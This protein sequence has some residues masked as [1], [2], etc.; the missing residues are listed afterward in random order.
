[1]F[2]VTQ[3]SS[4][5]K[6]IGE[7]IHPVSRVHFMTDCCRHVLRADTQQYQCVW[8]CLPAQVVRKCC[9][10]KSLTWAGIFNRLVTELSIFSMRGRGLSNGCSHAASKE[11]AASDSVTRRTRTFS[12]RGGKVLF[13]ISHLSYSASVD[14]AGAPYTSA[15]YFS[16]LNYCRTPSRSS[17]CRV[18][19]IRS[20]FLARSRRE[21]APGRKKAPHTL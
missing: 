6:P 4:V 12:S 14:V 1:M 13:G 21:P 16:P 2:K 19:S 11:L 3:Y 7:V 10:S 15:Q 9:S 5:P 8:G 18:G 20:P 17:R